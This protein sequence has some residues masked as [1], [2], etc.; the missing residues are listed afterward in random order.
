MGMTKSLRFP[1]KRRLVAPGFAGEDGWHVAITRVNA[2]SAGMAPISNAA[3]TA[4]NQP[5][6][7]TIEVLSSAAGDTT[8]TCTHVGIDAFGNRVEETVSLAGAGV[9]ATT[10]NFTY[11]EYSVLS[12]APAGNVTIQ[13]GSANADIYIIPIGSVISE[14]GHIFSG[15]NKLA[16]T[17]FGLTCTTISGNVTATLYQAAAAICVAPTTALTTIDTLAIFDTEGSFPAIRKYYPLPF[18]IDPGQYVFVKTVG[19]GGDDEDV[20]VTLSGYVIPGPQSPYPM[21]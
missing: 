6:A 13:E 4:A 11:W 3:Y 7:D 1:V 17:E 18:I 19:E 10:N 20:V 12:A 16:I 5:Q 9:V 2:T 21:M 8:Q 15:E 14:V